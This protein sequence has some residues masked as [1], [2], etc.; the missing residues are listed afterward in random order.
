MDKYRKLGVLLS[1]AQEIRGNEPEYLVWGTVKSV[2]EVTCTV[3][4]DGLELTGALLKATS[5]DTGKKILLTPKTGSRVLVFANKTTR[6]VKVIGIDEVSRIDIKGEELEIEIDCEEGKVKIENGKTS[7]GKI[8]NDL[9]NA[10]IAL[11]VPIPSG[12]SGTPVNVST[13]TELK[14][15][16]DSLIS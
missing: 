13:F 16:V 2:E 4:I 3:D 14:D 6:A 7:L 12:T 5:D 9:L 11:T 15:D 1:S 8:L 10:I